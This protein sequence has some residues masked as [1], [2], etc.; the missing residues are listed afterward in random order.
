MANNNKKRPQLLSTKI[1]K[2]RML[3]AMERSMSNISASTRYAKISRDTHYRWLKEDAKYRED[4]EEIV[5]VLLDFSKA[6]LS[7]LIAKGN[8]RAIMFHLNCFGKGRG[9]GKVIYKS[10]K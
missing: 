2:A 9:Y 8:T 4:I 7:K 3:H 6:Q 5:E 10:K 1:K